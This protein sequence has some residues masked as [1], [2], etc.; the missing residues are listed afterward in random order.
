M[1]VLITIF[2]ILFSSLQTGQAEQI[3]RWKLLPLEEE[4]YNDIQLSDECR[5][6]SEVIK[7]AKTEWPHITPFKFS[8]ETLKYFLLG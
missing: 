1:R 4:D 2:V 7:N 3:L 6:F 8:Q 5:S